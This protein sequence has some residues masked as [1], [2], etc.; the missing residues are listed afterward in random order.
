MLIIPAAAAVLGVDLK[1]GGEYTGP[2]QRKAA[3][4]VR[5]GQDVLCK[6]SQILVYLAS[7]ACASIFPASLLECQCAAC[8][9]APG[10]FLTCSRVI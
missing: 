8:Q 4:V 1:L 6:P 2:N 9:G 5:L 3:A 7:G 10:V